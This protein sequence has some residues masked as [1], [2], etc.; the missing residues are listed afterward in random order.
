MVY[1]K[2][3]IFPIVSQFLI[4]FNAGLI[5]GFLGRDLCNLWLLSRKRKC[6]R[7]KGSSKKLG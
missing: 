1:G 5:F 7:D 6:N 3:D 4:D 2:G